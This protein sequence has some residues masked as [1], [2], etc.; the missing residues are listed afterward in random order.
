[1]AKKPKKTKKRVVITPNKPYYSSKPLRKGFTQRLPSA[2][3]SAQ[4]RK[5]SP[6][7]RASPRAAIQ[8][9]TANVM[10]LFRDKEGKLG[11]RLAVMAAPK[12]L[13][14]NLNRKSD[15]GQVKKSKKTKAKSKAFNGNNFVTQANN[16]KEI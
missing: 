12:I 5:L 11:S 7:G 4:Y 14:R 13:K 16:Y 1:M 15:G 8:N 9:I 2:I 3:S 10:D 6:L